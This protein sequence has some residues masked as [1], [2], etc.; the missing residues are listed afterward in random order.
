MA[1]SSFC[2]SHKNQRASYEA[3]K[4]LL[5]LAQE[6]FEALGF[7]SDTA[8]DYRAEFAASE[9]YLLPTDDDFPSELSASLWI[10]KAGDTWYSC[11]MPL[12][13]AAEDV[14][15]NI[16]AESENIFFVNK[17]NDT[18]KELDRLTRTM[19]FLFLIAFVVI[20][21]IIRRFY[22]W[23]QTIRIFAVPVFVFLAVLAVLSCLNIP[24][25]FFSIVGLVLVFGLGLDFI[26]YNCEAE[27]RR[28]N[29]EHTSLAILLTFVTTALSFGALALSNFAP[30]HIFGITV[31]SG[32]C[33]AYTFSTLLS[34][35]TSSENQRISGSPSEEK[36]R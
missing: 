29:K 16:A 15:R 34:V 28:E 32:L 12:H 33:A 17:V 10:G 9:N 18:Q 25:G 7:P 21:I 1:V 13:A 23:R 6:Q 35:N 36:T 20:I 27:N 26:F 30:V 4:K 22:S 5:P 31:F 3:A 8:D 11:V 2:P 24:L 19:L 14:Y